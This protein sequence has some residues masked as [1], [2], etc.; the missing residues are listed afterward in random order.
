[1]DAMKV[2]VHEEIVAA[3]DAV[4]NNSDDSKQVAG[5]NW[6]RAALITGSLTSHFKFSIIDVPTHARILS[7]KEDT[8]QDWSKIQQQ[9]RLSDS[10]ENDTSISSILAL[11]SELTCKAY[12][13]LQV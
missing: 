7:G 2:V 10:T 8:V 12:Y 6:A 5:T 13:P 4:R 3:A 11:S 9:R 1:M